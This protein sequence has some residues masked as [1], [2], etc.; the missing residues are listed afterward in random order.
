MT[1]SPGSRICM[2][3]HPEMCQGTERSPTSFGP[4]DQKQENQKMRVGNVE[5]AGGQ[6]HELS[7]RRECVLWFMSS[8]DPS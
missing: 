2:C 3:R 6:G 7:G 4:C 8:E 5:L 1:S